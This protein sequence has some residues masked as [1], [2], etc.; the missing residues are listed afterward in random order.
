MVEFF[1]FLILRFRV[2]LQQQFRAKISKISELE[3]H[4]HETVTEETLTE[5]TVEEPQPA[6]VAD[7]LADSLQIPIDTLTVP[8]D[9][10]QNLDA[11]EVDDNE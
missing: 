8:V 11:V 10:T 4:S 2:N 7:T 6:V 1:N 5:E 9:S 3:K